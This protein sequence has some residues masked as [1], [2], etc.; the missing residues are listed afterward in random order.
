MGAVR[1]L[2]LLL[3]AVAH[4]GPA[5][6]GPIVGAGTAVAA[7]LITDALFAYR[8][9]SS[10]AGLQYYGSESQAGLC[11]IEDAATECAP[12]DARA[13]A[14]I[15]FAASISILNQ[16]D[17]DMYP[18]LQMYPVIATAIVPVY[19]LKGVQGLVLT[20]TAVA[21]IFSGQITTWDDSRITSYN[22]N[23]SQW[24]IPPKQRIELVVHQELNDVTLVFKSAM[25]DFASTFSNFV[26]VSAQPTWGT[27]RVTKKQGH[28]AML[29]Y[30]LRT[31][32][33]ISYAALMHAMEANVPR[34]LIW[35]GTGMVV[36]ASVKTTTFAVL[37][38][39][40]DFGNN[41]DN[42][43]HL[44][45]DLNYARG[46]NGWPIAS[47][48]YVVLRKATL[49]AGATCDTVRQNVAFWQWFLTAEVIS[50]IAEAHYLVQPPA[51]VR[52]LVVQRLVSDV[53]CGGALVAQEGQALQVTA[54]G[55]A[56]L[57]HVLQQLAGV[58][59]TE[60]SQLSFGYTSAALNTSDAVAAA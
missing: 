23:F 37:E 51:V 14:G 45:A 9:A 15:D 27:L 52:D 46:V 1:L 42:E 22:A 57:S 31:P 32:W 54:A 16:S 5:C 40:L 34:A 29:S 55:E 43:T 35:K 44:T 60:D 20:R 58:Y 19:N 28:E 13:P 26:N 8:F 30:V 17:Y 24:G 10:G 21:Q 6:A 3:L 47:Y 4:P 18:D 48:V 53:M 59:A 12:D 39:G 36:E 7:P 38:M 49:R 25:V 2:L 41:G 11:R 56:S 50:S 33:A